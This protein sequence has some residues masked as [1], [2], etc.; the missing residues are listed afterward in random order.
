MSSVLTYVSKKEKSFTELNLVRW[1][2]GIGLMMFAITGYAVSCADTPETGNTDSGYMWG[3]IGN[4]G[5]NFCYDNQYQNTGTYDG[6]ANGVDFDPEWRFAIIFPDDAPTSGATNP[7]RAI[8]LPSGGTSRA[9]ISTATCPG[10]TVIGAGSMLVSISLADGASCPLRLVSHD[11]VS[12]ITY[13]ATLNRTG[14]VYWASIASLTGGVFG[15]PDTTEPRISSIARK[16]PVLSPTNADTLTWRITFDEGVRNVFALNFNWTGTTASLVVDEINAITYDVTLSG[17]DLA[18]LNGTVTLSLAGDQNIQ[19]LA[20]NP[21]TNTTPKIQNSNYFIVDNSAPEIDVQRPADTSIS[22]DGT[23]AQG[24]QDAGSQVSITYTVSNTG[25][26]ALGVTNID[27]SSPENVSVD[28]I[29]TRTLSLAAGAT[30]TFTV[31]YTPVAF[32]AFSFDLVITSND[33]DEGNY[34]ITVSGT[35]TDSISP[36]VEILDTPVG[37]ANND[38]FSVTFEFSE[39]VTGFIQG[40]I[41][42][43]NGTASGF[44]TQSGSTYTADITPDGLGD[45]SIDVAA[46]VAQD[47]AGNDNTAAAQVSVPYGHIMLPPA[48]GVD[49]GEDVDVSYVATEADGTTP[50]TATLSLAVSNSKLSSPPEIAN[51]LVSAIDITSTSSVNGYVLIVTFEIAESSDK[52]F[53][54]F[55]KYGAETSGDKPQWYDYGTLAANGNGTGYEISTDQKSLTIYL[56]DGVRGDNDWEVNASITDPALLVIRAPET[57]F[58]DGFEEY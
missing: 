35:G 54:G 15:V 29:S 19:D 24:S 8:F 58:G 48:E 26:A 4:S 13:T 34:N 22:D 11:G 41:T 6:M 36:D 23:D 53:T 12:D 20:G 38:P 31:Q 50:I 27:S 45:I 57:I 28:S 49:S 55:W 7:V 2:V 42:V 25:T 30:S 5:T 47:G 9:T 46:S 33:A 21:L 17:G 43:G 51:S 14:S 18:D 44:V 52:Q 37:V 1:L 40:D 32:G 39:G 16:S 56:I 3:H 10:G